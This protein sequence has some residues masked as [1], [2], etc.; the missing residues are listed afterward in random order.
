MEMRF[1]FF[2]PLGQHFCIAAGRERK[3]RED[4]HGLIT[5]ARHSSLEM[6]EMRC[7]ERREQEKEE[8]ERVCMK[9]T[10]Y[11]LLGVKLRKHA[12]RGGEKG[13]RERI[14]IRPRGYSQGKLSRASVAHIPLPAHFSRK[15][16]WANTSRETNTVE[17]LVLMI[18]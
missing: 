2:C 15:Q 16:A 14:I 17:G 4:F 3:E 18:L 7:R 10:Y 8:R 6:R 1:F 5:R 12:C 13:V 9:S 11:V